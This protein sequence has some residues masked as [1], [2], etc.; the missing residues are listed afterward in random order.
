MG[1]GKVL[2]RF[3][4]L[5]GVGRLPEVNKEARK[6]ESVSITGDEGLSGEENKKTFSINL[7]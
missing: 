7:T 6:A 1:D 2:G 5:D 3:V 4:K